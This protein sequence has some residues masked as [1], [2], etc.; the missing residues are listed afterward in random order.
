ML[1]DLTFSAAGDLVLLL[2]QG[3]V[4]P[5]S[6]GNLTVTVPQA[7]AEPLLSERGRRVADAVHAVCRRRP[8]VPAALSL[9]GSGCT[10]SPAPATSGGPATPAPATLGR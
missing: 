5:F 1:T 10:T 4:A 3:T 6:A 7:T 8:R 2:D 9:V